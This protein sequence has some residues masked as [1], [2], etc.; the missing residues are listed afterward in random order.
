MEIT[1]ELVL[2]AL[3]GFVAID[4][5]LRVLIRWLSPAKQIKNTVDKHSALLEKD[6]QRLLNQEE[7]SRMICRTLIVMLEHDING[8]GIN[9]LKAQKAELQNHLIN[10]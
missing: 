1:W 8:N 7:T 10:K 3:G 2:G 6:H 9:N 4:A 5:G